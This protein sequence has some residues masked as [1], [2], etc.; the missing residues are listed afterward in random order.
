[1]RK[2]TQEYVYNYLKERG[3]QLLSIY[4]GSK[5]KFQYQCECGNISEITFHD[6]QA[7]KRCGCGIKRFADERRHTID[8]A[9]KFFEDRGCKLLEDKYKGTHIPMRYICSCVRESKISFASFQ[10]GR[11]CKECGF[12]KLR[13]PNAKLNYLI[14]KKCQAMLRETLKAIGKIKNTKT[15]ILLGYGVKELWQHITTHP[16][17]PLVKDI[18]WHLDHIFPITA[19]VEHNI[20]DLKIINCL[21]NLRPL[22]AVENMKKHNKYD[23]ND[24]INWLKSKGIVII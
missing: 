13:R 18:K 15:K 20:M 10:A 16:N 17:W 7:G 21:D 19:F 14:K 8:F 6:F 9:K 22:D 5:E 3:C 12:A 23:K 2:L 4:K 24:F 11:R 1:M